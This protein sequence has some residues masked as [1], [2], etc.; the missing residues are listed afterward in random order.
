MTH[1][2]IL[3]TMPGLFTIRQ[4]PYSYDCAKVYDIDRDSK[5]KQGRTDW[6]AE[7]TRKVWRMA[8]AEYLARTKEIR[9]AYINLK[10]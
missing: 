4:T 3:T 1:L 6:R 7:V 10:G 2:K 5:I 9:N 8:W